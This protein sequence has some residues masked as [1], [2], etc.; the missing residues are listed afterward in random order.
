MRKEKA[1]A[2]ELKIKALDGIEIELQ[3][4]NNNKLNELINELR[5]Q[6]INARSMCDNL[7]EELITQNGISLPTL[8]QLSNWCDSLTGDYY[9]KGE[10]IANEIRK[11]LF[12]TILP[13]LKPN[14]I[15]NYVALSVE[16][17]NT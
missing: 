1:I 6:H 5:N 12:N 14:D 2:V 17:R 11:L 10:S 15:K 8:I 4:Y 13:R 16:R 3:E 7:D 9:V